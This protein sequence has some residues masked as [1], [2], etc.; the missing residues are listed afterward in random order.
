MPDFE[1]LLK[2]CSDKFHAISSSHE[3]DRLVTAEGY[4][5]SRSMW[6]SMNSKILRNEEINKLCIEG[7]EACVMAL[8]EIGASDV[9]I[10]NCKASDIEEP[11]PIRERA[12]CNGNG[13][14]DENDY[15]LTCGVPIA[16]H[17]S[18]T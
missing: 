16:L 14:A 13:N 11:P 1:K 12:P 9:S 2:E 10:H 5:M 7:F 17:K 6:E 18:I 3:A 15:C 4:K 8:V